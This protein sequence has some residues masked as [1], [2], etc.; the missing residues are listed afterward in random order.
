MPLFGFGR[1][2]QQGVEKARRQSPGGVYEGLREMV[3]GLDAE[4]VRAEPSTELPHV[5]GV[6]VDWAVA[7]GFATFVALL[8][9]TSSMYTSS[10]GGIIGGHGHESVRAANRALLLA[11]EAAHDHL[12][13][14]DVA[15]VPVPGRVTYWVRTYVGLRAASHS[16]DGPPSAEPWLVGLGNAFQDFVTALRSTD[17][18]RG[19]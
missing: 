2:K 10:G 6:I 16:S 7:N 18:Q 15:E 3:L 1:P 9:G 17:E 12:A 8:D 4:K 11:A 19:S 14:A 5:W 13:T